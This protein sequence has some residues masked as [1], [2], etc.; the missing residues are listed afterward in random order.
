MSEPLFTPFCFPIR[1]D[2]PT[3]CQ[4]IVVISHGRGPHGARLD[5]ADCG[6]FC[7]WLS[8]ADLYLI[9]SIGLF[10]ITPIK[11]LDLGKARI[12][13]GPA[14]DERERQRRIH[15]INQ[16]LTNAGLTHAAML[17]TWRPSNDWFLNQQ[18]HKIAQRMFAYQLSAHDLVTQHT[19]FAASLLAR[20]ALRHA[21]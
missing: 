20:H 3:C 15:E 19:S 16:R 14:A 5:C 12:I 8:K 18:R 17:Q 1:L 9:E 7:G 6:N 21:I 4:N 13:D 11:Q 2:R 10:S